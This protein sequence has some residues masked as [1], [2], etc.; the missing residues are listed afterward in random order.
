MADRWDEG[1]FGEEEEVDEDFVSTQEQMVFLI[2]ASSSM[3]EPADV[4]K[5]R[6]RVRGSGG[7]V[8]GE[9]QGQDGDGIKGEGEEEVADEEFE[10]LTWLGA[11]VRVAAAVMRQKVVGAR[12]DK[13]AV[14]L[15][16]TR[17][18]SA[19]E[20]GSFPNTWQ[21]HEL[22]A[23]SAESIS[24]LDSFDPDSFEGKIGTA[25]P[26]VEKAH[27]LKSA[28]WVAKVLFDHASKNK[29][30]ADRRI[31]L[32]TRD[33][34]PFRRYTRGIDPS[35]DWRK[36]QHN[37]KN[38]REG[39][40][41]LELY[42]MLGPADPPFDLRPFWRA[43]LCE[44]KGEEEETMEE[45]EQLGRIGDLLRFVRSK[46]HRKRAL[47]SIQLSLGGEVEVAVKLYQLLQPQKIP[48][49][50]RVHGVN[51]AEVKAQTKMINDYTGGD[52]DTGDLRFFYPKK[53]CGLPKTYVTKAELD[54]IKGMGDPG[55]FLL[56]FKPVSCLKEHH[57]VRNSSFLYPDDKKQ[58]GSATAFIALHAAM[59][60]SGSMAICR[61]SAT[62]A[63]TPRLVA[64][65]AQAESQYEDG[66]QLDPPGMHVIYLPYS[67]DI[68]RPEEDTHFT[69]A[70]RPQPSEEAVAAAEEVVASLR[71][72][73]FYAGGVRNPGLQRH[74]EVLESKA[75]N[76]EP[77]P[78]EEALQAD[79][80]QPAYDE[81]AE[82]DPEGEPGGRTLGDIIQAFRDAVGLGEDEAKKPAA[83]RKTVEPA[84]AEAVAGLGVEA[85]A[86]QGAAALKNLKVDDLKAWLRANGAAV[87]G[88]KDE[89]IARVMN[90]LGF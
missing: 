68:R 45:E 46:A 65:L 51:G 13:V 63:R 12:G 10:G 56:G 73:G 78:V 25:P 77:P 26:G 22:E 36:V 43:V 41:A 76:E 82:A 28:L 19:G 55:M 54:E 61:L 53:P 75:L 74:Y 24:R 7:G 6:R 90:K 62:R 40:A 60:Q 34:E 59:L 49:V 70:D 72:P 35:P 58:P 5:K 86:A 57:Q 42:P 48:S 32:F 44:L 15:Y 20:S 87:G 66:S 14:V 29:A 21:L 81:A 79:E 23:P 80:T 83:K 9:E 39:R 18:A 27:G 64:L 88:K 2:D 89:L 30:P 67:D 17:E 38:L 31:L 11:A 8:A 37:L 4:R 33:P 3:L 50:R 85:Q 1:V 71:L 52:V 84:D 47:T 69:G 16:Q